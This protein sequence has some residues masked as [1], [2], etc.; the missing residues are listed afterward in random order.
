MAKGLEAAQF[1]GDFYLQGINYA[2]IAQAYY[3][4]S[5]IQK[6]VTTG[7]LG[8][9]LLEKIGSSEWRQPAGLLIILHVGLGPELPPF[10]SSEVQDLAGRH[11]LELSSLES[12]RLQS[13]LGGFPYLVRSIFYQAVR[14]QLNLKQLMANA[15][16]DVGIFS[17][18]LHEQLWYLQENPSLLEADQQI[19]RANTP[20]TLEQKLA[21]GLKSLGLVRLQKNKVT[22]SCQLYRQY[23]RDRLA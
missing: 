3:S 16:T 2:Y 9:Y 22:V 21:F 18:H 12:I 6:T 23:F 10:T 1:V 20:I 11:G 7:C 13:L 19:I 8:V 15:A 5:I 17:H 4:V 14:Y